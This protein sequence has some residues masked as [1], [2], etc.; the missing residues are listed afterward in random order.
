MGGGALAPG[1]CR[2][3]EVCGPQPGEIYG[4]LLAVGGIVTLKMLLSS[5]SRGGDGGGGGGW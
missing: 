2:R 4:R 3:H 5:S 1:E